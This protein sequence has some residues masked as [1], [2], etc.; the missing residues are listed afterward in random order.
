MYG[1]QSDIVTYEISNLATNDAYYKKFN[2]GHTHDY[3]ELTFQ[4]A[5]CEIGYYIDSSV[6]TRCP[7]N[8]YTMTNGSAFCDPCPENA[9]CPG[10]YLIEAKEGYW[11]S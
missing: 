9:I 3:A 5:Q 10:T 6:C 8:T 11:K 4:F 2:T 1:D 7:E